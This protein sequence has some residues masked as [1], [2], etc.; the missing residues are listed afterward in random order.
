MRFLPT[1]LPGVLL[2]EPAV[3]RDARGF[4]LE[5]YHAARFA[6]AG[7]EAPFVQDNHSFSV[8]GTLRGLHGQLR[9]PQGK[10][11]RCTEGSV[12]DVA[13]DVRRGSPSFGRWAGFELSA[14]NFRQLWIPPGFLH[15][16]CALSER[17]QVQYKC[18]ELYRPEDEVGVVWN[19]PELAIH[20]PVEAPLLSDKDRALPRLASVVDRLPPGP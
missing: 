3:F 16:F 18:T 9:F 7:I 13:V 6:E 15:G 1:E 5:S 2:I 4:F 11:V 8:R 12:F 19:D 10:L 17:A 20:W 14:E